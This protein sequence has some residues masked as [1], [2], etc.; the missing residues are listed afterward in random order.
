MEVMPGDTFRQ[1]TDVFLRT[2][3]LLA[4]V[5]HTCMIRLHHV[6]VNY[7]QVWDDFGDFVTG[8]EDGNDSQTHPYISLNASVAAGTLL[9]YLG[10]PSGNYTGKSMQVNALPIRVFWHIWNHLFRDQHLT[11]EKVIDTTDGQDTTTA[12]GSFESMAVP[13]VCWQKDRLTAARP[14]EQLGSE[15]VVPLSGTAP[16][17]GKNMDF[18]GGDDSANYAQV[19]DA[20]GSSANLTGIMVGN[21]GTQRVFGAASA[22]GTG[23]LMVDLAQATGMS[24]NDLRLSFALQ[25]FMENAAKYGGRY[26]DYIRRYGI[27]PDDLRL[28]EPLLL[29][30]GQKPISFS[31]VLAHGTESGVTTLGD[32]AGQGVAAVRGRRYRKFFNEHGMVMTLMSILPRTVYAQGIDREWFR[33]AKE[34]YFQYELEDLG[35]QDVYNK[36]VYFDHTTPDGTF[37]YNSQYDEFRTMNSKVCG[38]FSDGEVSDHWTMARIFSSDP[39]LNST[40]V[41]SNPTNRIYAS[42]AVDEIM[43]FANHS[44]QARRMMKKYATPAVL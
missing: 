10:I 27:R 44:V 31:P 17:Y 24:I 34:D 15:T 20:T 9:N 35:E 6:F 42:T 40:F 4:P 5:F 25:H 3:P 29:G 36:E 41:T 23:E 28:K 26:S 33:E 8:G 7:S 16:I 2:T 39:S 19:R 14:W 11:T 32:M 22:I 13:Y 38:E 43:F 18:D 30:G 37:G 21:P 12:G 1:R